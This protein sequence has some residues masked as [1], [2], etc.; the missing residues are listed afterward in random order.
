MAF[1]QQESSDSASSDQSDGP[2]AAAK[3]ADEYI[4]ACPLLREDMLRVREALTAE[5]EEAAATADKAVRRREHRKRQRQA[6]GY[7]S[8]HFGS[9]RVSVSVSAMSGYAH[10]KG[11]PASY[12]LIVDPF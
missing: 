5:L 8:A 10:G 11:G 3:A 4:T 1:N 2:Q 12:F 7:V 6:R 9:S